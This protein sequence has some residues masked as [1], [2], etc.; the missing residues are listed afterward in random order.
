MTIYQSP[1]YVYKLICLRTD[2]FYFGSRFAHA[3][4][5][6]LPKD[7]LFHY[8]YSSSRA[9]HD[10][11]TL[12]G[13]KYFHY[14]II[15]ESFDRDET[16]WFEQQCIQNHFN[17][18]NIINEYYVDKTKNG[19]VFGQ[20]EE[21]LD[22][23][24]KAVKD[25][26]SAGK[27]NFIGGHVQREAQLRLLAEGKHTSQDPKWLE[28]H[29][30]KQRSVETRE[31]KSKSQKSYWSQDT[32]EIR[33]RKEYAASICKTNRL[34]CKPELLKV[35]QMHTPEANVKRKQTHK[36]KNRVKGTKPWFICENTGQVFCNLTHVS[37][38]INISPSAVG[39]MLRG[40]YKEMKG[41]RFRYLTQ[42]EVN[43]Y[44]NSEEY[45]NLVQLYKLPSSDQN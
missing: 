7:D 32:E 2:E 21:N 38:V 5:A 33:R 26:V 1:F 3:K 13:K 11:I 16:F 27:H 35:S 12:Y 8:Y 36:Y 22:K 23:M 31:R 14:E 18:P 37:E 44:L 20:T 34:K 17:D 29:R 28:N 19:R 40:R 25:L 9:V 41:Y 42:E 43:N 45:H 30:Q 6:R 24:I 39:M 4:K 15:F 10:L